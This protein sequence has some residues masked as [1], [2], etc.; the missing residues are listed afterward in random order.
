M[1]F[2]KAEV[3]VVMMGLRDMQTAEL[4]AVWMDRLTAVKL[5]LVVDLMVELMAGLGQN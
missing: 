2:A 4:K 3:L 5:E 1:V